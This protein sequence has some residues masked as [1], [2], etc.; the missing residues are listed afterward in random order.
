[1]T[2]LVERLG[3]KRV[4]SSTISSDRSILC[5]AIVVA[6]F[7]AVTCCARARS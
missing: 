5:A 3:R 7:P 6:T 2:F 1:V 4:W